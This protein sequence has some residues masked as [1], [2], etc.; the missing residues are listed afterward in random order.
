MKLSVACENRHLEVAKREVIRIGTA[1]DQLAMYFEVQYYD[2][3]QILQ[4]PRRRKKRG[5]SQ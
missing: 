3:V 2:G 1:L 5:E 4:V